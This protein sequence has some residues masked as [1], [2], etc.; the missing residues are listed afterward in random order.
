MVLTSGSIPK[1]NH[2]NDNITA[3]FLKAIFLSMF[4][5]MKFRKKNIYT[6]LNLAAVQVVIF[7]SQLM[8]IQL[9]SGT[10]PS[11]RTESLL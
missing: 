4:W 2:S 9:S 1:C 5:E 6:V 8:L 7:R 3:L 11:Y 10:Q